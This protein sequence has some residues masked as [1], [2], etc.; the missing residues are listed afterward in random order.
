MEV[1]ERGSA[2]LA[3]RVGHPSP[4]LHAL[5]WMLGVVVASLLPFFSVFIQGLDRGMVPSLPELLGRGELLV[6]A[7]VVT[8][9]GIAE[10]LLV[11]NRIP[12]AT[13]SSVIFL[14]LGGILLIVSEAL[15]YADIGATLLTQP[16]LAREH[17]I[18]LGSGIL[19]GFSVFC[20]G[21]SVRRAAGVR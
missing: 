9:G 19:F 14:L 17:M 3:R 21:T 8:I 2:L 16:R 13:F 6:I 1:R 20:G 5:V 4:E 12:Q 7:I 11:V 18:S 15:W 10:L